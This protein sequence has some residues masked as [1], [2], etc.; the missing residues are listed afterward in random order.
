[1]NIRWEWFHIFV[2]VTNS[3]FYQMY[4]VLCFS[5]DFVAA[6]HRA[7]L[8]ILEVD[9]KVNIGLYHQGAGDLLVRL[10]DIALKWQKL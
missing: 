7:D 10:S 3:R 6:T 2:V 5:L 4:N 9:V 8:G 1:M